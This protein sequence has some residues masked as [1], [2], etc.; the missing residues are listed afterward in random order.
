[1]Y[2]LAKQ[3]HALASKQGNHDFAAYWAGSNVARIRNLNATELM[4]TLIDELHQ[5]KTKQSANS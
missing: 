2:D 1:M 4:H 5:A 3:L